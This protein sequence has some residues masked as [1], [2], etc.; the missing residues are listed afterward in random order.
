MIT[1]TEFTVRSWD[2]DARN[3]LTTSALGRY[4]QE[5]A[6]ENAA[7]L[8]AG[9]SDLL[10]VGQTWVLSGLLIR[11]E[12]SL[13]FTDRFT[14]ETWPTDIERRRALRDFRFLDTD[15]AEFAV[16][17]TAWYCLD[18]STRRP[19]RPDDWRR[20]DW[21]PEK[22]VLDRDLARLPGA[23][24][25]AAEAVDIPLRYS[26]LDLNG[27]LTNTRYQDLLLENYPPA[28]LVERR[29]AELE[30]NF[31]AEARYPDTLTARRTPDGDESDTWQHSL[32]RRSD[33]R[34]VARARLVWR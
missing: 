1:R 12:R 5:A 24:G 10:A 19:V 17:S 15:G 34:D 20:T 9:Y 4:M 33:G 7:A 18:L 29:V 30:L 27:H 22:R 26:D 28:W 13:G 14:V 32:V 11:V 31:M 8:G 16:A 6:E 3:E 25:D 2:V 23:G 21:Y